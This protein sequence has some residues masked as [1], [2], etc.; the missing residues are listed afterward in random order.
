MKDLVS[1]FLLIVA[2]MLMCLMWPFSLQTVTMQEMDT[3][4][5]YSTAQA[6]MLSMYQAAGNTLQDLNTQLFKQLPYRVEVPGNEALSNALTIY[7]FYAY[8]MEE[9]IVVA[10]E[11]QSQS[12]SVDLNFPGIGSVQT[13][14][15]APVVSNSI[16]VNDNVAKLIAIGVMGRS[17]TEIGSRPDADTCEGGNS[18]ALQT[19]EWKSFTHEQKL[20]ALN[21]P[22]F[23]NEPLTVGNNGTNN[24]WAGYNPPYTPYKGSTNSNHVQGQSYP[25]DP[26]GNRYTGKWGYG[27]IQFT[28]GR[29]VN[30]ANW[31]EM[32]GYN[33]EEFG[34]QLYYSVIEWVRMTNG[35]E[36]VVSELTGLDPSDD[37]ACERAVQL[38]YGTFVYH[39]G[40]VRVDAV[41]G[42]SDSSCGHSMHTES[43]NN[44]Y[45]HD[46]AGTDMS[47][48]EV[49]RLFDAQGPEAFGG[50]FVY[51]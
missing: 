44:L 12:Q 17:Y 19:A 40:G 24:R 1:I 8:H 6:Q 26:N 21:N 46:Y 36:Y 27:L 31:S 9:A 22:N 45:K 47:I 28:A 33:F 49:C 18:Y 29:R 23:M 41:T 38:M 39:G 32:N 16:S 15:W 37:A 5:H 10:N 51:D 43:N 3:T 2:V 34:S 30:L 13:I 48:L 7:N 4:Q 14:S 50:S 42:C 25:N 11:A 35:I 20:V